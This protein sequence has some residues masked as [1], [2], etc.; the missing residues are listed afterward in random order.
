MSADTPSDI[1]KEFLYKV[2]QQFFPDDQKKFYQQQWLILKSLNYPAAWLKKRGV[3][4]P[5]D[6]Y[7]K[8]LDT[9]LTEIK[10]HGDTGNIQYF[11]GYLAHTIQTHMKH[12]EEEYYDLGK[13]FRAKA[14][15]AAVRIIDGVRVSDGPQDI[16]SALADMTGI[17]KAGPKKGRKKAPKDD[18]PSLF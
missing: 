1:A 18:Q 16:T 9:I 7:R 12:H 6:R 5:A 8:L 10:R 13:G 3:F 4:W 15:A 11:A 14:D 2:R 17:L